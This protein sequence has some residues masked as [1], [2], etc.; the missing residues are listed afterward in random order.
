MDAL[1]GV[2]LTPLVLLPGVAL[3]VVS[4]ASRYSQ[5]HQELHHVLGR[6]EGA[7]PR[8]VEALL[9]RG[10]LFRNALVGLYFS[11]STFVL[12]ALFG[13]VTALWFAE[14]TWVVQALTLLGILGVLYS[15]LQLT[16]E[17]MLSLHIIREHFMEV[18]GSGGD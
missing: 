5:L 15:A 4:T 7:S 2:W 8:L 16:R 10:T 9:K 12:A 14:S 17:S 11:I 1:V 13:G 3:L 6:P 18:K